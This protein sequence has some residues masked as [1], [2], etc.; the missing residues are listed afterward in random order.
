M[1]IVDI[2]HLIAFLS[3]LLCLK[4]TAGDHEAP[5]ESGTPLCILPSRFHGLRGTS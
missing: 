3:V 1:E 5:E 2:V 4:L